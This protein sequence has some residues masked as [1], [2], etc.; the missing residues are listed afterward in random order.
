MTVIKELFKK[1]GFTAN[2]G[3]E[4]KIWQKE[5]TGNGSKDMH[6]IIYII[7]KETGHVITSQVKAWNDSFRMILWF[8]IIMHP[9]K[10]KLG[11]MLL[12]CDNCGSHKTSIVRDT[13]KEVDI[14][15]AFLPPNMTSE[16]QVLDLVVN[17]PLKAHTR[18]KRANRLYDAFQVYKVA[19]T[20][21]NKI[22]KSIRQNLDFDPPKP[23]MTEGILDLILLFKDQ[24]NE[25][26]F[27]SCVNR[28]FIKTGTLPMEDS[29]PVTFVEYKKEILCGTM[30]VIPEGT[31]DE[32]TEEVVL[33]P[34]S[35]EPNEEESVERAL[36]LY[37]VNNNG[38]EEDD[39]IDSDDETN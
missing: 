6:K 8:E 29:G 28:S 15:V 20:E 9:I 7:H 18:T 4:L 12:W 24:F 16:L 21:N 35:S 39:S 26:K 19:R 23:T 1:A 34:Y 3:W 2:D 33:N 38:T 5:L 14:D 31:M 32:E 11:K 22:E 25:E 17:W 13:I 27:K 36:F 30:L 37:F 10:I